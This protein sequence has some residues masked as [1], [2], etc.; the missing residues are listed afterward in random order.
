MTTVVVP[1]VTCDSPLQPVQYDSSWTH[2]LG[3][4]LADLAFGNLGKIDILLG[5]DI[6]AQE[7][8]DDWQS[9]PPGSPVTF[10]TQY[11]WVLAGSASSGIFPISSI[12]THR[13][14][15]TSDNDIFHKFWEIEEKPN[16]S[17]AKETSSTIDQ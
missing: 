17:I 13:V 16:R 5:I 4:P 12:A 2:L 11:G 8:L 1:R 10:Q 3:I 6:Y 7:M 15:V 9:G 14:T